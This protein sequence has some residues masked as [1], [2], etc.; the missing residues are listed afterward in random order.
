MR[1]PGSDD[2]YRRTGKFQTLLLKNINHILDSFSEKVYSPSYS[3]Y[4]LP[5]NSFLYKGKM[6]KLKVLQLT[7]FM[8]VSVILYLFCYFILL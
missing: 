7:H 8:L 1:R 2:P 5:S 6:A 4:K 3:E